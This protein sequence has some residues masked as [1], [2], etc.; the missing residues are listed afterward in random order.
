M[1]TPQTD[2]AA[3]RV[4]RYRLERQFGRRCALQFLYQADVQDDWGNV[5][6]N[7]GLLKRQV[8][9]L[10]EAPEGDSFDL[11]WEFAERLVR[12]V[13]R[14]RSTL[15]ERI[16]AS[17]TNWTLSRMSIIDRNI[18]RLA[19]FELHCCEDVPE[20]T[21]LDEGVELAKAFGHAD[22]SRFVNGVLDRMLRDRRGPAAVGEAGPAEAG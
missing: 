4:E 17:A 2:D 5:E 18:L 1:S 21:A 12:G 20:L 11:A 3:S 13:L 9:E 8:Q 10:D 15:D 19:S 16:A 14:E 22:S 6:R 7:L